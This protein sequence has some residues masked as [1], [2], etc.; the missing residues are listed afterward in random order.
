MLDVVAMTFSLPAADDHSLNVQPV[1][2]EVGLAGAVKRTKAFPA[3]FER[4]MS[5]D[6]ASLLMTAESVPD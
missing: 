4:L 2:G 3:L 1:D 6:P 5:V